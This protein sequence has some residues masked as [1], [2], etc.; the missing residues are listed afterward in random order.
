MTVPMARVSR[1]HRGGLLLLL[2]LLAPACDGEREAELQHVRGERD[3]LQ[4]RL[5]TLQTT[6]AAAAP[7]AAAFRAL[8]FFGEVPALPGP[9]A[10]FEILSR[11][12]TPDPKTSDYP[13]CTAVFHCRRTERLRPAGADI[14]VVLT[15]FRARQLAPAA[16][17]EVG[18]VVQA[19][20]VP[21][22]EMPDSARSVQRVDETNA[23]DLPVFAAIAPEEARDERTFTATPPDG[24]AP[25][26]QQAI[27]ASIAAIEARLALHGSFARWH[28]Q[29]E[30]LR[31]EL[32][33]KLA[34]AGGKLEQPGR[35]LLSTIYPISHTPNGEW[36]DPQI[37]YFV[38]LRDQLAALG[39]DLIVVPFTERENVTALAFLDHPP[40]D[41]VVHA[42]REQ[43][44]LRLLQ[45]G[46]E[47]VD[48]RP[49]LA[50]AMPDYVN[51]FYDAEDG[52]PADGAIQVAAHE[53]A[54]RLRRYGELEPRY[55]TFR[56]RTV[57]Y[58]IPDRY[59]LFPE[60]VHRQLSYSATAVSREDGSAIQRS[61]PDAPILL[62][63]DSFSGV[64]YAFGPANA[65]LA[66]HLTKE[67]GLLVRRLEVGSGGP[68]LMVHMAREGRALT[69]GVRVCVYVFRENYMWTH[70]E[71]E[72][73]YRWQIAELPR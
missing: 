9:V 14:L 17:F 47:V 30:P 62:V 45:A 4:R 11:P 21:W 54:Q 20:L 72:T 35:I 40:A 6:I 33:A 60:R 70:S 59:E 73:K 18:A 43:F 3:E 36:P 37:A 56:T 10:T 26:Q 41:G 39:I 53:I 69:Q 5:D 1:A 32:Y 24:K 49:A 15:L 8:E 2:P 25:S 67:T 57:R 28:E 71:T 65:D 29:L 27:A 52:H 38:A 7:R 22:D 48:L 50:A 16:A 12:P 19:Q 66:A 42:F 13:D 44:H 46:I 55:T 61:V 31:N 34:A 68:Q 58:K 23:F 63:G 64:P 51:V